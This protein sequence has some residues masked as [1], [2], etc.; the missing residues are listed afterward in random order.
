MIFL[1][2]LA[3]VSGVVMSL[4]HFPQAYKIWRKKSA[5]SV[6][7]ITYTIFSVGSVIW[8]VYGIVFHQN[9]I[10]ISWIPGV[11]GS[12]LVLGLGLLYRNK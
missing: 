7:F 1:T 5:Q 9:A 6:S 8:L 2:Y 12:W 3:T 4:G 11:I 10:I